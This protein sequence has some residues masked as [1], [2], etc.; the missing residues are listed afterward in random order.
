MLD[1]ILREHPKFPGARSTWGCST[2]SSSGHDD[3]RSGVRSPRSPTIPNSFKARFNLGKLLARAE[4]GP[5]STEQMREVMRI[6]PKRPEGYLFLARGLLHEGATAGRRS[7]AHREGSGARHD[8]GLK[9]LGWFLMADVFQ[10]RQQPD[11][12]N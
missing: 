9:A 6:A 12:M 2:T 7:G 10:R 3:A 4:T 8:A 11:K 5:G 1:E